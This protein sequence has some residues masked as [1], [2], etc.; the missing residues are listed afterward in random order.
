MYL[1]TYRVFCLWIFFLK[2]VDYVDII[3]NILILPSI[4]SEFSCG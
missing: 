1:I 2:N 4:E 3:V